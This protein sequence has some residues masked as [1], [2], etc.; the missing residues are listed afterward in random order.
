MFR[1]PRIRIPW[2]AEFL[3]ALQLALTCSTQPHCVLGPWAQYECFTPQLICPKSAWQR[4]F[5]DELGK[6][7][8]WSKIW[9]CKTR[10]PNTVMTST[11]RNWM[12]NSSAWLSWKIVSRRSAARVLPV[13][14]MV[15]WE[16]SWFLNCWEVFFIL[17]CSEASRLK[18]LKWRDFSSFRDCIADGV[19]PPVR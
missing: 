11:L 14:W 7:H 13:V 6:I 18:M 5:P 16:L 4:A 1:V 17:S 19:Y 2:T 8:A 12:E 9:I 10:Q 15:T 3:Q